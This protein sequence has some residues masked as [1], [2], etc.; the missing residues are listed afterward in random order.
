MKTIGTVINTIVVVFGMLC[1]SIVGVFAGYY[2][3]KDTYDE[4]TRIRQD[5]NRYK[6]TY[7][8]SK[9]FDKENSDEDI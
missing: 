3:A 1:S 4:R 6:Y 7:L 8:G 2:L 5:Y 9:K